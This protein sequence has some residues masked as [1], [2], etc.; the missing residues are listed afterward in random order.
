MLKI[1]WIIF[2]RILIMRRRLYRM[3]NKWEICNYLNLIRKSLSKSKLNFLR[4]RKIMKNW[5][6]INISKELVSND[7]RHWPKLHKIKQK[8]LIQ[9][10]DKFI[11]GLGS[12]KALLTSKIRI[13]IYPM[14]KHFQVLPLGLE[15][16]P[17]YPRIN[18]QV[19][20]SQVV[21]LMAFLITL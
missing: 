19:L 18:N 20:L 5:I 7:I 3:K 21:R 11:R 2:L 12:L 16:Q 15:E 9:R 17:L 6:K 10:L 4:S 13:R 1:D 14:R 8:S